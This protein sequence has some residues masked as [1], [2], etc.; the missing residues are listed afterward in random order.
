MSYCN[1]KSS[2]WHPHLV[3]HTTLT[4]PK[5][6][7]HSPSPSQNSISHNDI[8]NAHQ[9]DRP[10]ES[11]GCLCLVRRINLLRGHLAAVRQGVSC[12]VDTRD[13]AVILVAGLPSFKMSLIGKSLEYVCQEGS[14]HFNNPWEW[15][16]EVLEIPWPLLVWFLFGNT[17]SCVLSKDFFTEFVNN[18]NLWCGKKISRIAENCLT[19]FQ[20]RY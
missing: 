17:C 19:F 6:H 8:N 7:F 16:F 18:L 9:L 3:D 4:S 10:R 20:N 13:L 11:E 1:N 14:L 5:P 15:D 12:L 2:T